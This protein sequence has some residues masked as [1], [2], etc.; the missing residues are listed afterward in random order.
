VCM[1]SSSA[2][3]G[4]QRMMPSCC[5]KSTYMVGLGKGSRPIRIALRTTASSGIGS[6][7]QTA[8]PAGL[9][10]KRKSCVSLWIRMGKQ[11]TATLGTEL[12][13]LMTCEDSAK[14]TL[15]GS[16]LSRTAY[17][18]RA[19]YK[20]MVD[21]ST[22]PESLSIQ[23]PRKAVREEACLSSGPRPWTRREDD[24]LRRMISLSGPEWSVIAEDMARSPE[25]VMLRHDFK[26]SARKW[27][28]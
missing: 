14:W 22:R 17:V 28:R 23:M 27:S 25:D 5:D 9:R 19:M 2:G 12:Y 20:R 8:L 6:S 1:H 16:L 18:C 3:H 21:S 7:L 13:L 4:V 10:R 24:R 26:L 11:H 15:I